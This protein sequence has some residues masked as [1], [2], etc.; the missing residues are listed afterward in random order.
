MKSSYMKF[1]IIRAEERRAKNIRATKV[2]KEFI[3]RYS[4]LRR[5]KIRFLSYSAPRYG[6][7]PWNTDKKKKNYVRRATRYER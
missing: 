6:V 5:I 1:I 2:L 3:A 7:S 4:A